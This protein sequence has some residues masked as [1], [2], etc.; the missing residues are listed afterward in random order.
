MPHLEVLLREDVDKLGHRG[1]IVRV[2]S[3]YARN[4]LLPRKLAVM[5]TAASA[6]M[7]E[8]HRSALARRETREWDQA[9][10]LADQLTSITLEFDRKVGE[11]GLLYGSVTSIDIAEAIKE[12]GLD[13]ERRR[14]HLASPIKE[15]GEFSVPVKLHREVTRSIKVIVRP[16]GVE[17]PPT[18]PAP[19]PETADTKTRS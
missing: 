19:P 10:K 4:Y 1:Q 15:P 18:P 3:G 2:K 6:K 7:I 17:A 11:H 14:I 13:V 8:Q 9:T 12:K 5:A 16:E